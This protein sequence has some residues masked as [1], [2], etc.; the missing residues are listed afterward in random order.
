MP[1]TVTVTVNPSPTVSNLTSTV[2]SGTAFT[3]SPID[4][5]DGIIP[6][7]TSY[8]WAAPVITGGITGGSAQGVS[9]NSISDTLTNPTNSAQTA[10]YTVT[11]KSGSCNGATFTITVTVNPMPHV[12]TQSANACSGS[13]FNT[14]PANGGGN[15]VPI[16]TTYDWLNPVVSGGITGGSAQT[17]QPSIS[18]TLSNPSNIDQRAIYSVTPTPGICVGAVF[19]DTVT[20]KAK[21]S[22][23][24]QTRTI[25]SGTAF[26]VSPAGGGGNI[27]PVDTTLRSNPSC[28]RIL[29]SARSNR[30]Y[31]IFG[32]Q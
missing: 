6:A 4:G 14:S 13:A 27:I 23:L 2:C 26:T 20:V 17:L 15:I 7:G 28:Q 16:G 3:L 25:C 24:D 9:Q 18:Q 10:T 1:Q 5:V 8:T 22:V 31:Y 11:P 29:F 19:F 30:S 21:P 12:I 32:I